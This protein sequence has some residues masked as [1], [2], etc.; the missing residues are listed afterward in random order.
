MTCGDIILC[1]GQ[2]ALGLYF[3]MYNE[4]LTPWLDSHKELPVYMNSHHLED[5]CCAWLPCL[6]AALLLA[7]QLFNSHGTCKKWSSRYGN[8]KVFSSFKKNPPSP[9][10]IMVMALGDVQFLDL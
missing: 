9:L 6:S 7:F 1:T 10:F 3:I 2:A 8:T 4:I 5:H